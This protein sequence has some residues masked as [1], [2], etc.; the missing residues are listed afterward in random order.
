MIFSS[1]TRFLLVFQVLLSFT[2]TVKQVKTEETDWLACTL[3]FC[4][5]KLKPRVVSFEEADAMLRTS[6]AAIYK[7]NEQYIEAARVLSAINLESANSTYSDPEKAEKYVHIAELF[8]Q[9]DD[10]VNAENVINRASGFVHSVTDW[11]LTLRYKVSYARIL[12]AKRKFLEASL[13]YYELSQ[14]DPQQ[15]DADDLA[16]LLGK[17]ITCALLASAGPQRSRILGTLYKDERVKSSEYASIL[18]KM[19]ME[20]LLSRKEI[21]EFEKSLMPHQKATLANGFSVLEQA[22]LEHNMVAISQVYENIRLED[23]GT[24]LDIDPNKAEKVVARMITENRLQGSID[25]LDGFVEFE[26]DKDS[27]KNFDTKV[28]SLCFQVN[29]CIEHLKS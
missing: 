14:S 29:E 28:Q 23:L 5:D 8:L 24:L 6:L 1:S 18:E 12:D 7:E 27:L 13:R 25:Q 20:Q 26:M 9:E 22:V 19:Y 2:N 3:E 15:V 16:E 10:T 21:T 17:A 4:L 11:A